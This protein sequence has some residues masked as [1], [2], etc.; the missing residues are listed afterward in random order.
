MTTA[1]MSKAAHNDDT[2]AP[3]DFF[4]RE[5]FSRIP[6]PKSNTCNLPQGTKDDNLISAVTEHGLY[7]PLLFL[8]RTW[9][10]TIKNV[11]LMFLFGAPLAGFIAECLLTK[12][13]GLPA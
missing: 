12:D 9:N 11:D 4:M 7:V 3:K 1:T 5:D 13:G 10:N 2:E 8:S 6:E